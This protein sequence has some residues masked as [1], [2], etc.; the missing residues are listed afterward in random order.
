MRTTVTIVGIV[1]IAVAVIGRFLSGV[2]W[3]TDILAGFLIG[4]AIVMAYQTFV[5]GL[6]QRDK[7]KKRRRR[8]AARKK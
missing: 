7:E 6:M 8:I 2:H 5:I 1:L 4:S 3:F